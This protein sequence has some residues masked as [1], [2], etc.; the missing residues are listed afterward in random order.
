[1]NLFLNAIHFVG[2]S[3]SHKNVYYF[4][5]FE[6]E[7]YKVDKNIELISTPGHTSTC[8]SLIVR[9]T[10]LAHHSSVGVVGDLFEKE[11]D[12]FDETH[13]LQV[14]TE[15]EQLQ[16]KNRLRVALMVEKIIPGHGPMFVVTA[17]MRE[18][19]HQDLK[20]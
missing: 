5:D 17:E 14:G 3:K 8:V 20:A 15:D 18:K 11:E 19:L 1:M 2:S 6:K 9:N 12:V 13:W 16:R 10:N 4:H 7:S